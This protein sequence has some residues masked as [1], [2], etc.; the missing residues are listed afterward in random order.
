[1]IDAVFH[2]DDNPKAGRHRQLRKLAAT[3]TWKAHRNTSD[4]GRHSTQSKGFEETCR[5]D[6]KVSLTLLANEIMEHQLG[7][8]I[9]AM[10]V[11]T[12]SYFLFPELQDKAGGFFILSYLRDG[13]YGIGP[14]DLMLVL[15]FI[16]FFTAVRAAA[17]DFLL[18]PLAGR[19][20]VAKIRTRVRFAEQSYMII[21]YTLYWSWGLKLFIQHTPAEADTVESLLVSLWS[22]FP[23]LSL[24]T[25]FKLY[26]L[27]QSA[28]WLQQ[29]AVLHLEVQRKDH[30]QML[31]H[32]IVTVVLLSGSYSYRQ[33][34]AGNA[35]LVCMDL[36]DII[37][38]LA[39]VLRYLSLQKIC[40][41][42]FA[43]FVGAWII[44]RHIIFL[45]ICWS[46]YEHVHVSTMAYGT[47]STVTGRMISPEGKGDILANVF[48]PFI[49]SSSGS[50]AFNANIRWVFL[51][52][53][54]L[55]QCITVVWFIMII[56]AIMRMLRGERATDTRS[57][58]EEEEH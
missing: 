55:L 1:M 19:L 26:Y 7:L 22:G 13:E 20:G 14:R 44:T 50:V 5:L 4:F 42:A 33:W 11:V 36:V 35:V 56:K 41:A 18:M 2:H 17:L 27:S 47:Y 10:L 29:I 16:V 39:K 49:D 43:V 45:A 53:L 32:H 3:R 21:Y 31:L 9:N 24:H 40:D 12:M 57:E 46:I 30:A 8:S 15:G 6:P 34:R 58:G 52:L 37:L 25:G 54:L 23:Q 48:Q 28:F 38:P 51:G